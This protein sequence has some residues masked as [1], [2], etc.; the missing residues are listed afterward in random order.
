MITKC[1]IVDIC[2]DNEAMFDE[3]NDAGFDYS[4]NTHW[5]FIDQME[6]YVDVYPSEVKTLENIMRWYV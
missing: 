4:C 1:Y 3:L 2:S 5:R 6:L